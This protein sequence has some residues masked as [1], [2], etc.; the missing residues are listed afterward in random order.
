[1]LAFEF[2]EQSST[3]KNIIVTSLGFPTKPRPNNETFEIPGRSG[4]LTIFD[5]TYQS[6]NRTITFQAKLEHLQS[7]LDWLQGKGTISF[8][9]EADYV[10]E[11][12][13]TDA[14]QTKYIGSQYVEIELEFLMQPFKFLK[15]GKTV[16]LYEKSK[17]FNVLKNP[18]QYTA[19]PIITIRNATSNIT[20]TINQE[21]LQINNV[22]GTFVIDSNL[23]IMLKNTEDISSKTIGDFPKLKNGDNR[24]SIQGT[25]ESCEIM[26]NWC[27]L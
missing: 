1:M 15:S 20:I 10:Y 18:T 23:K 21:T 26:C 24:I 19:N 7:I 6:Y 5:G 27:S 22:L 17:Q 14:I 16:K 9:H 2:N 12:T 13:I 11:C 3:E 8:S 4:N 25:Y